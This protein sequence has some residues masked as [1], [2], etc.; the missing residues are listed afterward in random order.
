MLTSAPVS[1]PWNRRTTPACRFAILF[2]GRTGSSFLV[3][4]LDAHPQVVAEGER[5]V[6]LDARAQQA[7]LTEFYDQARPKPVRA[8]GFKTKLKDV[9]DHGAFADFL[10]SREL[11]IVS[12]RRRNMVKL[13][14]STLNARRIHAL[15][16]RWNRSADAPQLGPLETSPEELGAMVAR[17]IAAQREVDAYVGALGLPSLALDYE[18]L[19]ADRSAWLARVTDFLGVDSMPLAGTIEKA[20]DDDLRVALADF[21]RLRAHFASESFAADF[22]S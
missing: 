19:L 13:A 3:S 6:R 16:G 5:L 14:V 22:T 8:V 9:W 12:L 20:T 17:C 18:E 15:T 4:C 21:D 7:W 1:W 11:R 2:P 10:R